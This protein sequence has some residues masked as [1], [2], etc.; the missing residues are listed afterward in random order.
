MEIIHE[1]QLAP[2]H[3]GQ[4]DLGRQAHLHAIRLDLEHDLP[5]DQ[6]LEY[7]LGV[8]LGGTTKWLSETAPAVCYP[9]RERPGFVFKS[10]IDQL[11]HGSCRKPHY[12]G[13]DALA[14]VDVQLQEARAQGAHRQPA[15]LLF[16]GDQVYTD[17][18]AG[19][20]LYAISQLTRLLGLYDEVLPGSDA[21]S[22]AR[23]QDEPAYYRRSTLLPTKSSNKGIERVLFSGARKPIFTS[24][25]A[26]NHLL[27]L[28]EVLAQYLMCWSPVPWTLVDL[29]T[30]PTG[31][32]DSHRALYVQQLTDL[33]R[34]VSG[35]DRVR[36]VMANVPCYMIF[37][38]HDVTDDWNLSQAWEESAYGQ[39][40]AR[41][42]IGNALISYWLFQAWGNAPERFDDSL[43]QEGRKLFAG[44]PTESACHD[45][46]ISRLL[47]YEHWSYVIEGAPRV[48][49][50]DTRTQRWHSDHISSW[51]SG[52]MDWES[53]ADT[54]QQLLGQPSVILV[55][56][57]PIFGVKLIEIVQRVATWCGLSLMIDAENWM[58]H[59][60]SASAILN[61]FRHRNTP[62]NFVVL[63]GDAHYAFAFDILLRRV[64]NS[65]E[66]WQIT[67]SGLCNSFP[68]KLLRRFDR[69]N[70]WLF[71]SRSPLNWLTQRRRM[72]IRQR[73]PGQHRARY[74]HQRLING[75]GYGRVSFTEAGKPERIEHVLADGEAVEFLP[76]YESDW[77]H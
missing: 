32:P 7:D 10:R 33:K 18:I 4:F 5:R 9:G 77:V 30:V 66:I 53:L 36:R 49:V 20:H 47:K 16:T 43:Q 25:N 74:R 55:S 34:F 31:V 2:G 60:G 62:K 13:L 17:D 54:Q 75:A 57:A 69:L 11:L 38:D 71:A 23:L 15:M 42:I 35:L 56:A 58:A 65:P 40:L 51:P 28:G 63:S 3:T 29:S 19:P 27:T 70:R 22:S 72:R 1:Q 48:L 44:D 68:E 46:L 39:P 37:D 12:S 61:I 45:R 26:E 76:G 24:I 73:R 14:S 8:E 21:L 64:K 50:L 41:R 59:R 67:S 6:W 52:L